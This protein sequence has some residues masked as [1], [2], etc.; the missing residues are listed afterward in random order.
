MQ[1]VSKINFFRKY[2][3]NQ[4]LSKTNSYSLIMYDCR[5]QYYGSTKSSGREKLGKVRK[6]DIKYPKTDALNL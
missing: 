3:N 1:Y 4:N 5:L 2:S 6:L